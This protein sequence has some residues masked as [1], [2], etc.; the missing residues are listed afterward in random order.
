[1]RKSNLPIVA[2]GILEKENGLTVDLI[3]EEWQEWLHNSKSF[4]YV[5]NSDK[6]A[7]TARKEKSKQGDSYW[8]GYRKIQGK[9]HKRYIGKS[10]ELTVEHL[11][12]VADLLEQPTVKRQPLVTEKPSVTK[13]L[14]RYVTFEEMAQLQAQ[15]QALQ[16]EVA[17]LV[18]L[19]AR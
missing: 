5:P 2:G 4:R 10:E 6:P 14:T 16:Q 8:Y 11:E 9:L 12:E 18:K 17:T 13:S 3:S 19:K 7:F 1:M 15:L